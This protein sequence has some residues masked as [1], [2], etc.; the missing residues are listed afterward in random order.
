MMNGLTAFTPLDERRKNVAVVAT[1]SLAAFLSVLA[2]IRY[3]FDADT[4]V[5]V[6]VIVVLCVL[7]RYDFERR[8]IPDRIVL[9]AWIGVLVAN[10]ALHSDR[11]Y[12]WILAS[13]G[14]GLFFFVFAVARRGALGMGDVKLALLIGAA[15]GSDVVPALIVGTLLSAVVALGILAHGGKAA[16]KR[17]IPLGPFLAAGAIIVILFV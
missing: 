14:A 9:P 2:V 13:L 12:E 17:T 4:V 16:R 11:W 10:V 15:L 1:Y 5:A 6:V 7:S 3:G 8:I